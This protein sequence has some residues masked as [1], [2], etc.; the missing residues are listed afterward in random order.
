V[1]SVLLIL[2]GLAAAGLVVD[3]LAENDLASAPHQTVAFLG[4]SFR[5]S[6]PEV[7]LGAA[8]L[9]AISVLLVVMGIG[10][11]RGSWGRRRALKRKIAYLEQENGELRARENLAAAVSSTRTEPSSM[12]TTGP[13]KEETPEESPAVTG[14]RR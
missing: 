6:T 7:V 2:L 1:G 9:G 8:V 13:A 3:F 4:G 5:L 10:L 11:F 14:Y 12:P